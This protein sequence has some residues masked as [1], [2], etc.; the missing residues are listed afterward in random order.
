MADRIVLSTMG[1][2]GDLHPFIAIALRLKER[3]Y[4]PVIATSPHFL[5]NV[6]AAGIA[7]HPMGPDRADIFRDLHMDAAEFGRQVIKDTLF[8]LQGAIYPYLRNMYDDLLPLIDGAALVL[9]SSLLFSARFAAERL[10]VPQ[11]T[12]VLQPMVFISAYDPPCVSPAPWLAPVLSKLGPGATRAVYGLGKRNASR[13]AGALHS[14]RRELGLPEAAGDPL[15]EGQYSSHGTFA[16]YS[17]LLG[18]VQPDYPPK[19]AVTGFTFYDGDVGPAPTAELQEFLAA[20][21]QPLVFTLGSFAVEFAG[22]FFRSSL[23]A[24][25]LLGMRAVV[26][27]GDQKSAAY[28]NGGSPDVHV[29]DYAPFTLLFPHARAI[30]HHGGIGTTG[31]ALRAG[32]PQLVVPFLSDQ[33]DNAARVVRLGV[34][35]T[36]ARKRYTSRRVAAEL[37]S[38]LGE[39]TYAL[40]AA[41]VGGTVS[42]EDGAGGVTR[43]IDF[44]LGSRRG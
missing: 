7:F 41:G 24:A 2:L 16:L 4:D 42:G 15:F 10:G 27:A 35:R 18:E 9:S 11:M 40:R 19:T 20:G 6:V 8:I 12:V 36:I 37:R 13:R 30:I 29:C 32:K 39:P 28:R 23:D 26:L 31:Q 44:F 34:A 22:N 1:S 33:F 38:L 17:R 25:R 14:F 5:E 3:G 21:P 43:A